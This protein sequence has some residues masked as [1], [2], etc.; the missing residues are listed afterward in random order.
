M[1]LEQFRAWLSGVEDMQEDDWTP[2]PTQWK[3]IRSKF[4]EIELPTLQSEHTAPTHPPGVRSL[5]LQPLM[6][7][8]PSLI[9]MMEPVQPPLP[10]MRFESDIIHPQVNQQG[11]PSPK[12]DGTYRSGFV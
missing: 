11:N 9:P 4:D 7:P 12:V 10:Q 2:S 5:Q 8:A 6:E 1:T 3:K